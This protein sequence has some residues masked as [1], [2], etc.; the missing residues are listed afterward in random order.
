MTKKVQADMK[1]SRLYTE[2][3]LGP[4]RFTNADNFPLDELYCRIDDHEI[5]LRLSAQF[6]STS[7]WRGESMV[8]FFMYRL[9]E[10]KEAFHNDLE[11]YR[12]DTAQSV[13]LPERQAFD[14]TVLAVP[15]ASDQWNHQCFACS[16]R[17]LFHVYSSNREAVFIRLFSQKGTMLDHPLLKLVCDN[18]SLVPGQ[19]ETEAPR[20]AQIAEV[21]AASVSES[22]DAGTL[23]L[24]AEYAAIT[25]LLKARVAAFDS[26]T[27]Y[28]PGEGS[29]VSSID[30]GFDFAQTGWVAVV[31]DT[32]P[33]AMPDGNW[34]NYLDED[35]LLSR[36][37]W[38]LCLRRR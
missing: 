8:V 33:N 19:W 21:C 11:G 6:P 29:T 23:D 38:P 31:F 32:R 17:N 9:P 37:Q 7:P 5:T 12:E 1:N 35:R 22:E 4:L 16:S 13:R 14:A 15:G 2:F 34:T 26:E 30:L 10:G 25:E 28:G 18:V 24:A 27:N 36:P 20:T 3:A